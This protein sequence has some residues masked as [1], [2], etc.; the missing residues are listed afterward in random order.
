[1]R[2]KCVDLRKLYGDRFKMGLEESYFAERP[3]FRKQERPW[4]THILC[5]YGTIGVW[6]DND[7]VACTTRNGATA[8]KLRKL[9]FARVAQDG[10]DGV[11]V[12]FDLK[13]FDEVAEIMK[14]RRRRQLS[15]QEKQRLIEMGA[16]YRYSAGAQSDSGA[17]VCE[18]HPSQCDR[19]SRML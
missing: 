14:P 2:P 17:P 8:S 4:L 6:G 12:V 1:M 7:L 15:E 19:A 16:K 18:G 5:Q 9:P 13:H 10:S 3:E 11:N